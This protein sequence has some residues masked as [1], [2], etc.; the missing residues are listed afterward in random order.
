MGLPRLFGSQKSGPIF[1]RKEYPAAPADRGRSVRFAT[2]AARKEKTGKAGGTPPGIRAAQ[3]MIRGKGLYPIPVQGCATSRLG[4][5]RTGPQ[6]RNVPSGP[7][8][9]PGHGM[10]AGSPAVI[11]P[12]RPSV[13]VASPRKTARA[14][15]SGAVMGRERQARGATVGKDHAPKSPAAKREDRQASTRRRLSRWGTRTA[16]RRRPALR[17]AGGRFLPGSTSRFKILHPLRT[18]A[19]CTVLTHNKIIQ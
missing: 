10:S 15:S 5:S 11:L 12:S 18:V 4:R 14:L 8:S 9:V 19:S 17:R 1:H 3:S 13:M 2:A 6:N 7:L 16:N